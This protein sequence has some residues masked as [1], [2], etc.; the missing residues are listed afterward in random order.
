M[1]IKKRTKEQLIEDREIYKKKMKEYR[2]TDDLSIYDV[3]HWQRTRVYDP[4]IVGQHMLDWANKEDSISLTAFCAEYGYLPALIWRFE[5]QYEFFE[6]VYEF[7]RMTLA[8]RRERLAYEGKM[9]DKLWGRYQSMFDS[10]LHRY[11]EEDKDR[12]AARRKSIVES[13][14][15]N[16]TALVKAIADGDI[17]QVT[18]DQ[19]GEVSEP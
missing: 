13:Q 15:M 10:I 7:T 17:S 2:S 9:N 12:Q 8:A 3:L 4:E 5:K 19:D 6:E 14:Q 1:S 18:K 16:L 11:E